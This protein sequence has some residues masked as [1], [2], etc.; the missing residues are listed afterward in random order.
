VTAVRPRAGASVGSSVGPTTTRPIYYLANSVYQFAYALPVYERVGGTFVVTSWKKWWHMHRFL[1]GRARFGERTLLGA[2]PVRVLPRVRW[3]ELEGVLF[4][5]ANAIDPDRLNPRA[6]TIF[7]EHGTSDKRY[8]GGATMGGRRL[9]AYDYL[10]LS[11]PKNHERLRDTDLEIPPSR[12][13]E[14]GALRFDDW[15]AGRFTRDA[16]LEQLG[17][18]DRDRPTILYAP[19]WRFGNGTLRRYLGPFIETL[20]SRYNLI[21]RPHYHDRR[22]GAARCRLAWLR[23]VRHLY[24]SRPEDLTRHDTYSA[25]AASDLMLSDMSSVIYEYLVTGKPMVAIQTDFAARHTMPEQMDALQHVALYDGT[26][27][28]VAM[29]ERAFAEHASRRAN[30]DRLLRSCFYAPDGGAADQAADFLHTLATRP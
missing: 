8:E 25:F 13:V 30:Y 20:T 15:C 5:L 1:R 18:R 6:I 10:F 17:V 22:Y 16:A 19:T 2:P 26:Q 29:I 23:G 24:L 28:L 27:D 12:L 11:G 4:Y 9:S 3:P 21:V 7:H 14:T